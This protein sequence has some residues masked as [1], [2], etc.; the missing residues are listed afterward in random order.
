M[1]RNIRMWTRRLSKGRVWKM[2]QEKGVRGKCLKGGEGVRGENSH[3]GGDGEKSQVE[4]EGEKSQV[5]CKL[6]QEN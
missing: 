3:L 2:S 1:M 6:Q 5:G 4:V